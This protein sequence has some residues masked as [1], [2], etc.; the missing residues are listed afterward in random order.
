MSSVSDVV[1]K[2]AIVTGANSGIGKATAAELFRRG[3]HV[4]M[5]CRSKPKCEEAIADIHLDARVTADGTPAEDERDTDRETGFLQYKHLDL[6]SLESVRHFAHTFQESKLPLN[7]LILNAGYW[8]P[9]MVFTGDGFENHFQV[10]HLGHFL[11][12]N[13]LM[14]HMK[15]TSLDC[16]R[17]SRVVVVSS[18]LHTRGVFDLSKFKDTTYTPERMELYCDTKLCN[19]LFA[20]QLH[21]R[22]QAESGGGG[23]GGDG[24]GGDCV[25][26][27]GSLSRGSD[28]VTVNSLCPGFCD[29][30]LFRNVPWYFRPVWGALKW[31]LAEWRQVMVNAEQ[32]SDTPVYLATSDDVE[33]VSG[34]FFK[35]CEQVDPSPLSQSEP[36]AAQ[37]WTE[38]ET[39]VGLRKADALSA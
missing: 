36:E 31:Y 26:E 30:G 35:K 12:T 10:N 32:G 22:L 7:V 2:V 33:G 9:G 8:A 17:R 28:L 23:D 34:K 4:V 15:R 5:A 27:G 6:A 24:D 20:Q 14:D 16:G 13:L 21:R 11:L 19:V 18:M 3:M 29:T 37:L 39:L 38:S 1:R 25:D